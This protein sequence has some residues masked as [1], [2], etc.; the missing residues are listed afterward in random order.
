MMNRILIIGCGGS[1]KST[2]AR[3]LGERLSLPV[4]HL[5]RLFWRSG[6]VNVSNDEFDNRLRD[7]LNTPCWVIDGNYDR[8]LPQRLLSCDTVI[9]LDYSRFTCLCGVFWRVIANHGRSRPDMAEGCPE[10]LDSE[11]LHWI[12]SYRKTHRA[13]NLTL[14]VQAEAEGTYVLRFTGRSACRRWL[15][16][17]P[18]ARK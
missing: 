1:G 6:W 4:W 11:F 16:A 17:L 8:T 2:L 5:D 15:N 14:L 12:W 18:Y 7:V 9:Y 13:R 10:R 3:R